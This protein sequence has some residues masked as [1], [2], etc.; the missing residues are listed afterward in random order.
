M[1]DKMK[2]RQVILI[3]VI[4]MISHLVMILKFHPILRSSPIIQYLF[5]LVLL[6]CVDWGIPTLVW[7]C[8]GPE[9]SKIQ[10]FLASSWGCKQFEVNYVWNH[11]RMPSLPQFS[12]IIYGI[13]DH[14]F[15]KIL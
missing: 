5:Y 8:P 3:I 10:P 7:R 15:S 14:N 4:D 11:F 12:N 1:S 13:I 2:L 9:P 6:F